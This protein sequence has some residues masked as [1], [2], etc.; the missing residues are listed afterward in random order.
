VVINRLNQE[1]VRALNSKEVKEKFLNAGIEIVGNTPEEFTAII[2]SEIAR[3]GK[4]IKDAGIR[5]D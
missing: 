2:N 1:I 5:A 4:I 3:M